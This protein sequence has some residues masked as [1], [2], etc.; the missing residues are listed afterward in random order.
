MAAEKG[1]CR[2]RKWSKTGSLSLLTS[3]TKLNAECD[4]QDDDRR[5]VVH[6]ATIDVPWQT[7][8]RA[9]LLFRLRSSL[10]YFIVLCRVCFAGGAGQF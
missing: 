10:Q 2:K 5:F 8:T 3:V 6:L 7:F 9:M 1:A 4:Q